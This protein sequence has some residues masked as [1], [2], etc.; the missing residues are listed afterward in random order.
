MLSLAVLCEK[1]ALPKEV[2]E[3]VL[4]LQETLCL[5]PLKDVMKRME[6]SETKVAAYEEAV[7]LL[8]E[9]KEGLKILYIQLLAAMAQYEKYLEKGISEEIFVGTMKCFTRFIGE[10]KESYGT[11]AFDRSWWTYRQVAM[12][13]FRIGELEYE[14]K[15][16]ETG[17]YISIHIPSDAVMTKENLRNSYREAKVFLAAFYPEYKDAPMMCH[18]WLLSPVLKKMLKEGSRILIF[19]DAFDI[20]K[21]E[22]EGNGFVH[23]VFKDPRLAYEDLP[24]NTS[25]QRNLKAYLLKGGQVGEAKGFLREPAFE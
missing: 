6:V 24:E 9:D 23:W 22:E 17:K 18:S 3:K 20:T 15:E 12:E 5:E 11:Y 8:G 1:L 21:V 2:I 19:Q 14:L 13:L 4:S 10:H 16:N 25:L 7:K